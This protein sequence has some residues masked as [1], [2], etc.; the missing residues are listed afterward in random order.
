MR[1]IN[2]DSEF[3]KSLGIDDLPGL[4]STAGVVLDWCSLPAALAPQLGDLREDLP[5]PDLFSLLGPGRAQMGW[6]WRRGERHLLLEVL[7]SGT[8]PAAAREHLLRLVDSWQMTPMPHYHPPEPFG[9]LALCI[10]DPPEYMMWVFRNVCVKVDSHGLDL[11]PL[12]PIA[13]AVQE[14]MERHTVPDIAPHIPRPAAIDVSAERIRVGEVVEVTLRRNPDVAA[15]TS[16]TMV[17]DLDALGVVKARGLSWSFRGKKPGK[18]S[19]EV[20]LAHDNTL[21]S[22]PLEVVIEVLP[23]E[24]SRL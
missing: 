15:T 1:P 20:I 14:L 4:E 21:L 18:A 3:R 22:P 23:A 17:P 5:S 16:F 11:V 24:D 2:L 12:A 10:R 9:D 8:G 19:I 7:V 6:S 13:R